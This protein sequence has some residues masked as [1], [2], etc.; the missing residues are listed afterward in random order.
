MKDK[1]I[2][3][4]LYRYIQDEIDRSERKSDMFRALFY[5]SRVLQIILAA[6]ITVIAGTSDGKENG[7]LLLLGASITIITGIETL[8]QFE[9]KSSTYKLILFELREIRA[10]IVHRLLKKDALED[11]DLDHFFQKYRAVK[12]SARDMILR[13]RQLRNANAPAA[14]NADQK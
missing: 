5:A 8:F 14:N 9:L 13:E 11:E 6:A 10:E 3:E 1:E 12:G 4:P 7:S 2:K